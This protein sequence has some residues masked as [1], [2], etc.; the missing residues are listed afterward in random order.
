[1]CITDGYCPKFSDNITPNV[2]DI[3]NLS[4]PLKFKINNPAV[5]QKK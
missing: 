2:L 1:M 3:D 5:I 4:D